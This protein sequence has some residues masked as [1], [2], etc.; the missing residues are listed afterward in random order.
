M[1]RYRCW[2]GSKSEQ[3]MIP[4]DGDGGGGGGGGGT[5]TTRHS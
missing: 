2:G 4:G 1:D 3:R 5:V